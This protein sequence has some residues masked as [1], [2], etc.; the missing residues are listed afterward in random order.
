MYIININ[1]F[2]YFFFSGSLSSSVSIIYWRFSTL[3]ST[4]WST[5]ASVE[6][7]R[8]RGGGWGG[9][10]D[11]TNSS[12]F[13]SISFL[14]LPY[15]PLPLSPRVNFINIL[16]AA[17]A[18]TDPKS[19]IKTDNLIVFFLRFQ[20]LQVQK[21]LVERQWNRPLISSISLS[22]NL[23]LSF[24]ICLSYVSTLS[25]S[26]SQSFSHSLNLSLYFS[27]FSLNLSLYL[28]V[29]LSV[30]DSLTFSLFPSPVAKAMV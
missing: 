27:L 25:P 17:F 5:S 11:D 2:F 12:P 8:R 18:R 29:S 1:L 9:K 7:E 24:S 16:Q 23:S 19:V 21:L 15:L 3:P 30:S 10:L 22:T 13:V 14:F 20:D 26:F 6:E 4:S 28:S